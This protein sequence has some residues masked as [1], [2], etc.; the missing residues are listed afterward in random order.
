VGTHATERT[1]SQGDG[2]EPADVELAEAE[3]VPEGE[4]PF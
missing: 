2:E 4:I 1:R 3:D